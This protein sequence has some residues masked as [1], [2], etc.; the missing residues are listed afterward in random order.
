ME[1]GSIHNVEVN[2]WR[3][4]G[5]RGEEA[6]WELSNLK[7]RF[8]SL[9][10]SLNVVRVWPLERIYRSCPFKMCIDHI[11]VNDKVYDVEL[12]FRCSVSSFFFSSVN[13]LGNRFRESRRLFGHRTFL[14]IWRQ[15]R[16]NSPSNIPKR[17]G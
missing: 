4:D 16:L 14:M 3:G 13:P 7:L 10:V 17:I 1:N 8:S 6:I 5:A 2:P 9:R 15:E 12:V 11:Q